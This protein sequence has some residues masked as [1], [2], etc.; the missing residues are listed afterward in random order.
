MQAQA[1]IICVAGLSFMWKNSVD[2]KLFPQSQ[3]ENLTQKM[4]TI[5]DKDEEM[6]EREREREREKEKSYHYFH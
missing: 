3:K 6:G 5:L 4:G 1:D 2:K